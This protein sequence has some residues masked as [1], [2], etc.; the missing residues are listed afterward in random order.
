MAIG[1]NV[2]LVLM[3]LACA[4]FFIWKGRKNRGQPIEQVDPNEVQMGDMHK[5]EPQVP[6]VPPPIEMY[7]GN[8]QY[9]PYQSIITASCRDIEV[10]RLQ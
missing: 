10:E 5:H 6:P 4:A 2:P 3:A 9:E 7:A 8:I 1:I